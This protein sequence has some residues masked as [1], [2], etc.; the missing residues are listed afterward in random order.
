MSEKNKQHTVRGRRTC[1][2]FSRHGI[3]NVAGSACNSPVYTSH[4]YPIS[5][6]NPHTMKLVSRNSNKGLNVIDVNVASVRK[7]G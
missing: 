4:S 3:R 5:S 2:I 6:T 7:L 1:W